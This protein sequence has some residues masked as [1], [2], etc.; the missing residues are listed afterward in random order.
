MTLPKGYKPRPPIGISPEPIGTPPLTGRLPTGIPY[1]KVRDTRLFKRNFLYYL[2]FLQDRMI[3]V[4]VGKSSFVV[5]NQKH[6]VNTV[7]TVAGL[8]LIGVIIISGSVIYYEFIL[9]IPPNR[10]D[11]D[12][13]FTD[14]LLVAIPL[15]TLCIVCLFYLPRYLASKQSEHN[16]KHELVLKLFS[17]KDLDNTVLK[18]SDVDIEIYYTEVKWYYIG[19]PGITDKLIAEENNGLLTFKLKENIRN[20]GHSTRSNTSNKYLSYHIPLDEDFTRC[21]D[22]LNSSLIDKKTNKRY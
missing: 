7:G 3:S 16:K 11:G 20:E 4:K 22:I 1:F 13:A 18:L 9:G 14:W 17:K 6:I 5:D 10:E 8:I 2:F 12:I 15:T 21:V 19:D